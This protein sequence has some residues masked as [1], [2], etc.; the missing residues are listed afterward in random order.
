MYAEVDTDIFETL[1]F[2]WVAS[3]RHPMHHFWDTE[4]PLV[5]LDSPKL[6]IKLRI[7]QNQV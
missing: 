1:L 7:S 3:L 5:L 4:Q 6:A 2:I